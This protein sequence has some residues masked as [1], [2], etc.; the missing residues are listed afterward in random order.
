MARRPPPGN[1]GNKD[2][3]SGSS[4]P[5]GQQRQ[6]GSITFFGNF[7]AGNSSGGAG[8]GAGFPQGGLQFGSAGFGFNAGP[9]GNQNPQFPQ[10][11]SG[12]LGF[13]HASQGGQGSF[14]LQEFNSGGGFAGNA[15]RRGGQGNGN[16]RYAKN[17]NYRGGRPNYRARGNTSQ[18]G[19]GSNAKEPAGSSGLDHKKANHGESSSTNVSG[20]NIENLS[21]G[22]KKAK[23]E[24]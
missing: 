5:F 4:G 16:Q 10:G 19:S 12:S 21:E 13:P 24:S 7:N 22:K 2:R 8:N 3:G 6:G 15:S 9:Q 20:G 23:K 18:G 1:A 17:S 14:P 11:G